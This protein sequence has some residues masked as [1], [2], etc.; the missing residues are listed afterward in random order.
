MIESIWND[1]Y[2]NILKNNQLEFEI[3]F[4]NKSF[5]FILSKINEI[6]VLFISHAV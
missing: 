5:K 4:W 1:K 6:E 3:L 2:T